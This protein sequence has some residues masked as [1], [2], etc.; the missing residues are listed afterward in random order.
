VRRAAGDP[1]GPGHGDGDQR[2]GQHG[3]SPLKRLWLRIDSLGSRRA[4][5]Q[6]MCGGSI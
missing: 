5:A 1:Q 4:V 2:F 3:E 6:E